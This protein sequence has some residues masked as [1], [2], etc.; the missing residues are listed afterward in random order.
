MGIAG[1]D[2]QNDFGREEGLCRIA[3]R[4]FEDGRNIVVCI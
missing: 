3:S 1:V 2:Q 4:S